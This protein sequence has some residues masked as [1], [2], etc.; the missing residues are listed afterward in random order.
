MM[1]IASIKRRT[2]SIDI[3]KRGNNNVRLV[4]ILYNTLYLK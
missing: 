2:S 3:L 1:T 4:D